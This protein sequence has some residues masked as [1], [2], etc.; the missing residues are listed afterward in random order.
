V[1]NIFL[2]VTSIFQLYR[3]DQF[4]WWRKPEHP[5]KPP[6][7]RKSHISWARFELTTLLVISTDCIGPLKFNW[8]VTDACIKTMSCIIYIL[9]I[10]YIFVKSLYH[11]TSC[12]CCRRDSSS[13]STVL[14]RPVVIS[15]VPAK[16]LYFYFEYDE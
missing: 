12:T 1:E 3:G 6:T 9:W 8:N 10:C 5:K 13:Q 15:L 7:C 14:L 2:N 16:I 4:Y 11:S